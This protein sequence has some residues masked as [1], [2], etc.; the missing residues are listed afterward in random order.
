VKF[1]AIPTFTVTT[2]TPLTGGF[3][4]PIDQ[5]S[6]NKSYAF[7]MSIRGKCDYTGGKF[8]LSITYSGS[9]HQMQYHYTTS[10]IQELWDGAIIKS[11]NFHVI[12]AITVGSS[13]TDLSV[14]IIDGSGNTGTYAM[15]VTGFASIMEVG[16]VTLV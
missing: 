7:E 4:D 11:Y 16:S 9:G 14:T 10:Q 1:V 13:N 15:T 3:S 6:A 2:S 8:S 12:G 5:L